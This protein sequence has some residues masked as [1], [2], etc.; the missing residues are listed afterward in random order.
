VRQGS[1]RSA[2]NIGEGRILLYVPWYLI[3]SLNIP[4]VFFFQDEADSNRSSST[5]VL[6]VAWALLGLSLLP[7]T[8]K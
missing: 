1:L 3:T 7:R 5:G 2:D 8:H 6:F 4:F